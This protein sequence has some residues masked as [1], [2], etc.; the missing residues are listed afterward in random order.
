MAGQIEQIR[1]FIRVAELESF[2]AAARDLG[3]SRSIV[4]RYVG[5][6]ED[7]L[8]VQL[9][10]RTTR[11]VSLTVAG[12]VYLDRTRPLVED[13]D[14]ARD[15]VKQQQDTLSGEIRISAPVSF[16]QR[17]LPDILHEFH[18]AHP[19]VQVKI[20]MIDRFVDLI[21]EGYDMALRISGPPSGVS[22]IWRK[23]AGVPRSIVAS[24]AYL[25][26][27]GTPQ[28]PGDLADHAF[29][30]YSHFPGGTALQ[31]SHQETGETT[32]AALNHWFETNSGEVIVAL[33][34]KGCGVALMPNFLMSDELKN[35]RLVPLLSDWSAP[36][37]WLTAFYPPYD[38]MP[39]KV[40]AFTSFVED[41]VTANPDMLK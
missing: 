27:A 9:L 16:G 35:R 6:L 7:E 32:A 31:L 30:A 11:K 25:E 12:Q 3:V 34:D 29:L 33:A 5:E 24:P 19:D 18:L 10:V 38:K 2:A 22:N 37:I 15:L 8:G 13:L 17:F 20:E 23:I 39:A 36:A 26:T 14:R 28:H 21:D 41:M 4:T 40:A 1:V